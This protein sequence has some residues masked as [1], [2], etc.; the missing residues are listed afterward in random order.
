M[1]NAQGRTLGLVL[2]GGGLSFIDPKKNGV[3]LG[4]LI[5]ALMQDEQD[6]RFRSKTAGEYVR[7]NRGATRKIMQFIQ[8]KRLL[9]S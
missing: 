9:T 2:S 3:M 5:N 4:Q 8:E 1:R 7:S 6:Y